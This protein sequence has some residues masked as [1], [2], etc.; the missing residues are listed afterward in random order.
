MG[1]QL[2]TTW[3]TFHMASSFERDRGRVSDWL[4]LLLCSGLRGRRVVLAITGEC[5]RA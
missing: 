1:L 2:T 4:F 3:G 5:D